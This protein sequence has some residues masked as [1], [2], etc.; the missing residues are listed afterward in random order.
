[1]GRQR[2]KRSEYS[3]GYWALPKPL[4][5]HPDFRTLTPSC[6]KVLCVI[7]SQFTGKN[8]GRLSATRKQLQDWGGMSHT[9]LCASLRELRQRNLIQCTREHIKTRS[10]AKPALYALAWLPV[11][12]CHPDVEPSTK[13]ARKLQ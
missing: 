12:D 10:G 7:G 4:M 2:T 8:N 3:G 1:M 11:D 13:P 6:V 5:E 9:T